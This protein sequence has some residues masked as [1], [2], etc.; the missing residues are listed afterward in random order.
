[1]SVTGG[2]RSGEGR[3]QGDSKQ[4]VALME[5]GSTEFFHLV[6]PKRVLYL[7]HR[8]RARGERA[9][10]RRNKKTFGSSLVGSKSVQ[11]GKHRAA[12]RQVDTE[13]LLVRDRETPGGGVSH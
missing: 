8:D 12:S 4:H 10:R 6:S 2:I 1:M 5:Q 13:A 9:R 3:T 7:V 11:S